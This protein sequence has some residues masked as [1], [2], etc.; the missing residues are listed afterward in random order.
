[1]E[2]KKNTLDEQEQHH[3][4]DRMDPDQQTAEQ[5]SA[6]AAGEPA[7]AEGGAEAEA[8]AADPRYDE[9]SKQAEEHQQRYLRAQADFDNFRRRTQKEKEELAQ[10]ASSKLLTQ[11]LPVVDNFER[12]LAAA[13]GSGDSDSLAK[14][15]DMIFRQLQGVLEQEG[16]KA[17]EAVG[18]PFNPEFHQAIMQVESEDHEE[19]IVVEEVQKGYILK[20]K[21]L[22]PAMVKVSG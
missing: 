15:V 21:V 1:M 19:G 13:A 11:L 3:E 7:P 22:R 2:S 17:M 16:L 5:A 12:A 14:G 4:G 18:S 10:Y 6:A 20:D 9:L 8:P